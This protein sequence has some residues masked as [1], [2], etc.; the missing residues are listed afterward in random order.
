MVYLLYQSRIEFVYSDVAPEWK[1]FIPQAL[2][3]IFLNSV[4]SCFIISL[5]LHAGRNHSKSARSVGGPLHHRNRGVYD[6]GLLRHP[7]SPSR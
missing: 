6:L 2:F 3:P 4:V 5:E 1:E 7:G